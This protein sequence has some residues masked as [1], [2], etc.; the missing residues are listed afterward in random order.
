M[1]TNDDLINAVSENNNKEPEKKMR[2]ISI[3]VLSSLAH[4]IVLAALIFWVVKQTYKEENKIIDVELMPIMED[5]PEKPITQNLEKKPVTNLKMEVDPIIPPQINTL[6]IAETI[7]T[8]NNAEKPE[9]EGLENAISNSP[10]VGMSFMGTLGMGPGSGSVYSKRGKGGRRGAFIVGCST[11]SEDKVKSALIWLAKHQEIDGHWDSGKYEGDGTPEVDCAATGAALLAFLAAGHTDKVG[12][13]KTNVKSGISWLITA[14]RP[15]GSW[16]ARNYANGI[17][18]MALAEAA[19]MGCGGTEVKNSAEIAVDYLLKQQNETG[20]FDYTGPSTR[21]D[22]SVT[23]WCI[24]ALKSASISNIRSKEVKG[25]F[26]KCGDFLDKTNGTKDNTST[27][28][29][30]GWYTPENVGTGS[31]GGACQAIAMLVRQYLGWDRSSP[32]LVAA[33]DGQIAKTPEKYEGMDVYRV[34]YSFL[35]L[36][37]QGGK[38]WKTWNNTVSKVL[39]SSQ[40][41]DGDFKGSWDKNGS[42]CDKGGRVLYTAFLCLCLEI[43]YRY[44]ITSSK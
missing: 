18:T 5:I 41:Q 3:W 15:N 1:N 39:I 14:Q 30:L 25:A 33:A 38:H 26:K 16:D 35:T 32:W 21:D 17:C 11:A 27:S 24:M 12:Q 9:L 28:K 2:A 43:Y 36:F 40:R 20:C 7:E 13:Y 10:Q 19:G 29:G 42:H 34:Y 22:M 6:E 8:D 37:Q 23:G 31:E 4:G 44:D